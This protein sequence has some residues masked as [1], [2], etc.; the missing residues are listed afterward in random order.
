[1]EAGFKVEW[2]EVKFVRIVKQEVE[3][4]GIDVR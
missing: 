1:M 4:S 2:I 3:S